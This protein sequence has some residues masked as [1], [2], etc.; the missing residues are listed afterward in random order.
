[1]GGVS[2]AAAG[3]AT[4]EGRG[5]GGDG[6]GTAAPQVEQKAPVASVEQLGQ[7]A[8]RLQ[9]LQVCQG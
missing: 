4:R 3:G 1:M 7:A 5:G 8:M 2:G 9:S 6:A